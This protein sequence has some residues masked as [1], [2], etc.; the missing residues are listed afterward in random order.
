AI[1]SL[2][3]V[4]APAPPLPAAAAI[5]QADLEHD[6]RNIVA[7]LRAAWSVT[8][9][10][11]GADGGTVG[12]DVLNQLLHA[13]SAALLTGDSRPVPETA[14]WIADLMSTRGVDV[15]VVRELHT[16]AVEV[17]GDYP[18]AREIVDT[19]FVSGL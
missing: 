13:A 4:V 2:P 11:S 9:G 17:L 5:E 16:L 6:H 19:H 7:A 18:L 14:A 1:A 3:A 12:D 15:A 8:S 10:R